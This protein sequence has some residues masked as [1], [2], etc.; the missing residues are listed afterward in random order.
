MCKSESW[1][2][3]NYDEEVCL[4]ACETV[5]GQPA[6][7][8]DVT[9]DEAYFTQRALPT[10]NDRFCLPLPGHFG[11]FMKRCLRHA[12]LGNRVDRQRE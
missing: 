11:E 7:L 9:P 5:G 6:A 2:C 4:H 3:L 10:R 12:N 1:R 8:D